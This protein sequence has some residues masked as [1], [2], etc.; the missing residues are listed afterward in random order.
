MPKIKSV[1]IANRGE[2]AI[3]IAKTLKRLGIRV[4]MLA[5]ELD[6]DGYHTHFADQVLTL[7]GQTI[8]ETYLNAAQIVSLATANRLDAIHPGYGFLSENAPFAKACEDAGL[9]FIGPTSE[10]IAA[11]G[12]KANAKKLMIKAKVPTIPGYQG[13]D[14]S[15]EILTKEAKKIPYP[16]LI[17]ASAGGGG[18]GMRV[19]KSDSELTKAIESAKSEALK[20]FGDDRLII[21]KYIEKPHHIE[22]QIFGDA[23]GHL[24]HLGEREC[25][26]QR[27]HQKIIEE[28]PSP[29]LS[30]KIRGKMADAALKCGKALKYKNAGTVEFI[31]SDTGEFYFLEV[32]T[33]L[34]VEHP[35]T[36]LRTG[37]DLVEWQ[38]R[39][40]E[41]SELPLKQ[42]EVTF[43]GH[44]IEGRL[45]AED[46]ENQFLPSTGKILFYQEPMAPFLRVD[47]SLRQDS[48]VSMNFDPMISKVIAAGA[49]RDEAISRLIWALQNYPVLGVKTNGA[50]MAHV[51]N[52]PEFKAGNTTTDFLQNYFSD[53]KNTADAQTLSLVSAALVAAK[54][55]PLSA[56]S[57]SASQTTPS[58]NLWQGLQHFRLGA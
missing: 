20:S 43:R 10:C 40:A 26:I 11:M 32:N 13:D 45:Y 1:L 54:Q 25:S 3:R 18:K 29:S 51:L 15:L 24:I 6:P 47:S 7:K 34:Q 36:E 12:S 16:I 48:E 49:T 27:R 44:A 22:F 38:I 5:T 14:Q 58:T 37:L 31:Y 30:E 21:E 35:I 23:H 4:V 39:V 41:G 28:T 2:I 46:A 17:K 19:V 50:L 55:A 53:W 8:R 42:K 52:H 57:S 9:I 33:R 56:G